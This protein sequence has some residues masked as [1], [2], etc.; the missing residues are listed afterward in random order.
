MDRTIMPDGTIVTTVTTVQSRPR[1]DGK[2]GEAGAGQG[3]ACH[4]GQSLP[5]QTER[6]ELR[7]EW[8]NGRGEGK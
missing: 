6:E 2:L 8:M 7:W 3:G 5:P 1:M 4:H